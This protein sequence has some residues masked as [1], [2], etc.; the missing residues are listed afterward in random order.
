MELGPVSR[1]AELGSWPSQEH[2]EVLKTLLVPFTLTP[3]IPPVLLPHVVPRA[4][5]CSPRA[6]P[7]GDNHL[8]GCRLSLNCSVQ[9]MLPPWLFQ[10][11]FCSS[12]MVP[13][14]NIWTPL[15]RQNYLPVSTS[16]FLPSG[17]WADPGAV[18][19]LL[20]G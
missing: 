9:P 5:G 20:P 14:E 6:T 10:A 16:P 18:S 12:P 13:H 15:P 8:V 2:L 19:P 7:I 4:V 17:A 3:G 11:L 1:K